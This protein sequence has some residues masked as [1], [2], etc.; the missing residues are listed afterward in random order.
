MLRIAPQLAVLAVLDET[1]TTAACALIAQHP[2]L[3][4]TSVLDAV[5]ADSVARKLRDS[6]RHCSH[7]LA[8]YRLEV[9]SM[10]ATLDEASRMQ[11]DDIPF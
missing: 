10:I 5:T 6:L 9:S 8:D 11:P 4:E 7:V 3:A 2:S 1:L